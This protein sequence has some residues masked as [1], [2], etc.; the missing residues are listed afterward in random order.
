MSSE[1]SHRVSSDLKCPE[2]AI[3]GT[4]RNVQQIFDGVKCN[5]RWVQ[6]DIWIVVQPEISDDNHR[7]PQNVELHFGNAPQMVMDACNVNSASIV[8]LSGDIC[9]KSELAGWS[10]NH[11][12]TNLHYGRI[13]GSR[14]R[15]QGELRFFWNP[16]KST[17]Q[18]IL[19][20]SWPCDF[21]MSS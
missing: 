14:F 19:H 7:F 21:F 6:T 1:K 8:I 12:R 11:S 13:F 4:F 2:N 10:W 5:G 17:F 16:H 3:S 9:A 20:Q 15:G 18:I